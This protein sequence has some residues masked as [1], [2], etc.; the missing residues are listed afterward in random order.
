[1]A[2]LPLFFAHGPLEKVAG[3]VLPLDEATARHVG[4]VLRMAP[5]DALRLTDGEGWEAE[6]WVERVGKKE[7]TVR[8]GKRTPHEAPQPALHLAVAFTKSVSR[9]EWMLEKATE[10]GVQRITPLRTQRSEQSYPKRDRWRSILISAMLQ[11]GQYF[12]PVLDEPA[13]LE[14][15]LRGSPAATSKFLAHC[16]D[17]IDRRPLGSA[18]TN[19]REAT[20]VLIGPEGDFTPGEITLGEAHGCLSVS[21]GT[22]RLRTET[23]AIAACSLIHL[24]HDETV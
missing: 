24:I 6:A 13:P 8:V 11:S 1:M 4:T 5:G 18:V 15:V 7:V 21:L 10:L 19:A 2:D 17:G 9:N 20:L 3:N 14:E 12:L 23:A 22:T 16:N